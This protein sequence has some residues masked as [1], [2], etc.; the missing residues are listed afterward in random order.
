MMMGEVDKGLDIVRACRDRY[1]GR[2][3]NPFDEYEC[4]HWYARAMS[5]YAL[6]QGLTGIRYDA[7][8]QELF[9]ESQVGDFNSFIS[10]ETG[11]G[12][13]GLKDGKPFLNTVFGTIPVKSFKITGVPKP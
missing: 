7:L 11:F 13:A 1:D 5:S 12:N 10:T 9:I 4:G 3:R 6:L 8:T 2:V